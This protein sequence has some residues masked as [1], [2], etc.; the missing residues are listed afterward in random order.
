MKLSRINWHEAVKNVLGERFDRI[1][2]RQFLEDERDNQIRKRRYYLETLEAF[3]K[4]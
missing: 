1:S 2:S 4:N 3:L